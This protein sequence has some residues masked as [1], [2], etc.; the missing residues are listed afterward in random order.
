MRRSQTHSNDFLLSFI[1]AA[2]YS[3]SN[4]LKAKMWHKALSYML[5]RKLL[6]FD[7][8]VSNVNSFFS[9]VIKDCF[10][11][12]DILIRCVDEQVRRC[13]SIIANFICDYE[14]QMLIIDVKSEQHCIICHVSSK[15]RENLINQWALRTHEFMQRQIQRQRIE[16]IELRDEN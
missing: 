5:K 12:K 2:Y 15:D 7:F 8:E 16:L 11:S 4:K 9:S 10:R 3:S 6:R 14:E 13:L 1:S